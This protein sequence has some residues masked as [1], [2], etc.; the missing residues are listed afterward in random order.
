MINFQHEECNDETCSYFDPYNTVEDDS[1]QLT[2]V[3]HP[4]QRKKQI[5][6][7]RKENNGSFLSRIKQNLSASPIA[8]LLGHQSRGPNNTSNISDSEERDVDKVTL[9]SSTATKRL[10]SSR[11]VYSPS[12]SSN[13]HSRSHTAG[14]TCS[15]SSVS[16]QLGSG[17]ISSAPRYSK[18]ASSSDGQRNISHTDLCS[19][20]FTVSSI[21]DD[22]P[23]VTPQM[24]N[25]ESGCHPD[26]AGPENGHQRE[27]SIQIRDGDKHNDVIRG[28]Q[29]APPFVSRSS[30]MM[31]A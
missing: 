8:H 25:E 26:V 1:E 9:D 30:R 29:P 27:A 16:S 23:P 24:A 31:T 4:R 17:S 3:N 19:P 14:S 28:K 18:P 2:P 21:S 20:T 11:N 15:G 12:L 5:S 13:S 22:T 6:E 7:N 10:Y